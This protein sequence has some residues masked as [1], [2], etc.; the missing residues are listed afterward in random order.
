[1][2]LRD[3]LSHLYPLQWLIIKALAVSRS[4]KAS[5]SQPLPL[6]TSVSIP[7]SSCLL[8]SHRITGK[9]AFHRIW[10]SAVFW[11]VGICV[12]W[13]G[14][15]AS[16]NAAVCSAGG[17]G[18]WRYRGRQT[19]ECTH[20]NVHSRWDSCST[21]RAIVLFDRSV[22]RRSERQEH[23]GCSPPHAVHQKWMHVGSKCITGAL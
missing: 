23:R 19:F 11:S 6:H 22:L 3:Q 12:R 21:F 20:I 16:S 18:Q 5:L 2:S 14:V 10:W 4:P 1:M 8:S 17:S 15:W 7:H 9:Q 13:G